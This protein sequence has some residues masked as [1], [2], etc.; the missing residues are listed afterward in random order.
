[1]PQPPRHSDQHGI[2]RR[3]GEAG[4][5]AQEAAARADAARESFAA[6]S[7][8]IGEIGEVSRL[9]GDI[10]SRTNLLALNATIEAARA[11]DAGKGFA[12]VASEVKALAGQTAR[13]TEEIARR[14]EAMGA[15]AE[16]AVR[17][18]AAIGEA[19]E[20]MRAVS[21]S[22]LGA[23]EEQ[24]KATGR[25]AGAVGEGEASARRMAERLEAVAAGVARSEGT[26]GELARSAEGVEARVVQLKHD[27][28][29]LVRERFAEADRRAH[30]RRPAN[31]AALLTA[32]GARAEGRLIDLSEGGACLATDG[33][34]SPGP[35]RLE[36]A[37]YTGPVEVVRVAE[38]AAH[39]RFASAQPLGE[40]A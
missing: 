35:A 23:A 32:G 36:R 22:V 30:P 40:A 9:I 25:I 13:S 27:L 3:V 18:V 12:V 39:V 17:A 10:A 16:E 7:A 19:V 33:A 29:R 21:V 31:V 26:A 34:V 1:M 37:A 5:G 6:L 14:I 8:T 38:G 28:V 20:R 11:G 15:R 4:E 24:S 2:A